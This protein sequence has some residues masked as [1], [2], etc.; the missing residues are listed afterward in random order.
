MKSRS[1]LCKCKTQIKQT[2]SLIINHSKKVNIHRYSFSIFSTF[3]FLWAFHWLKQE[4]SNPGYKL[5]LWES[6]LILFIHEFLCFV[7]SGVCLYLL[8]VR[9]CFNVSS[10]VSTLQFKRSVWL[11]VNYCSWQMKKLKNFDFD[12]FNWSCYF[13]KGSTLDMYEYF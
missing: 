8:S 2:K 10:V 6:T 7:C 5:K 1:N 9:K 4:K 13:E 11:A 3:I 12:F